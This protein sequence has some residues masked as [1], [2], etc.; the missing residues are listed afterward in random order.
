MVNIIAEIH[1]I[2]SLVNEKR[3][4]GRLQKDED[5]FFFR[6][7]FDKYRINK[8]TFYNNVNYYLNRPEEFKGIYDEAIQELSKKQG[9]YRPVK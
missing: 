3:N 9:A 6:Q 7:L 2:E 1:L 4:T 5:K 8:E